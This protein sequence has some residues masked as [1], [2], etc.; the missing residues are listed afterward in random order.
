M[1][2]LDYLEPSEDLQS[3]QNGSA[4][5][6]RQLFFFCPSWASFSSQGHWHSER[7][8][9]CCH[10]GVGGGGQEARLL[11]PQKADSFQEPKI[12]SDNYGIDADKMKA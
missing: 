4:R 7:P 10:R 2:G 11:S 5:L 8:H 3:T 9:L 12:V 6:L 1:R